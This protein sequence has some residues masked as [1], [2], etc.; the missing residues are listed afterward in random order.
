MPG[1]VQGEWPPWREFGLDQPKASAPTTD[2]DHALAKQQIIQEYGQ[3]ALQQSW[4]KTCAQLEKIK[5]ECARGDTHPIPTITMDDIESDRVSPQQIVEMKRAGC[6][7]VRNVVDPDGTTALFQEL[8]EYTTRN[9]GRFHAWP[10]ESPSMYNLYNTPTQNALRTN[11]RQIRLMRWI[12]ELWHWSSSNGETSAEPLLYA[13]GLRV[14][15]AGSPFLGLGPHIDAGSLCRWA[16]PS[17]RAA[18]RPSSQAG[19]KTMMHT[20]WKPDKTPIR[21]FSRAWHTLR[22]GTILLYPNVS[23]VIA[24]VL[25]RPFF[26]A[27]ED[28]SLIMDPKAWKFDAE[29]TWFPGTF[30]PESQYLSD[31]SHPHLHLRDCLLHVPELQPGDTVWW[32]TDTCHAVDAEH[33]GHGDASVAYIAAT[34]TTKKNSIYMRDQYKSMVTGQPPMDYLAGGVDESPLEGFQGFAANP[35]V[36]KRMMGVA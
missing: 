24:Y 6:F 12:N 13:D 35:E 25:L 14:R 9:K 10:A 11:P 30:K 31:S 32:H 16:D 27:P 28:R 23:T 15:P 4:L 21:L 33:R 5:E 34:P 7:V 17:Y 3:E 20:I 1:I 36:F 22:E 26:R 19:Q 29:G 2:V 8:K 18:Y